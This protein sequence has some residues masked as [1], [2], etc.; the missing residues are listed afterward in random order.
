MPNGILILGPS[1]S[2][3]TTLGRLVAGQLGVAFLDIDDYIW[4]WDTPIP[5]TVL[6]PREE[7]IRRLTEAVQAAGAFVMAGSMNS[8]HAYFDPLFYLAVYLTAPPEVC[9]ARVH[10]RELRQYGER[11]LPG[12]DMYMSHQSFLQETAGYENDDGA[13]TRTQHE[14]WMR[15]L[16]CPIL[17]LNGESSVAANA[18]AILAACRA[19]KEAGQPSA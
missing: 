12:G 3:K 7:K 1:G 8:F 11:I 15:Q 13:C 17:R 4:R 18:A 14:A 9:V 5:Y 16:R 10:R 19:Q 6:H 2:G